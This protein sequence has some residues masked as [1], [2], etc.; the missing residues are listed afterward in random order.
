MK[1]KTPFVRFDQL[2]IQQQHSII[3][4]LEREI[5]DAKQREYVLSNYRAIPETLATELNI[6]VVFGYK[7]Q[8][9]EYNNN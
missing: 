3:A 1:Q 7:S 5:P 4:R 6:P 9:I 2:P 8:V